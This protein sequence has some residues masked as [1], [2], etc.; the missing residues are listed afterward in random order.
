MASVR[1]AGPPP[2]PKTLVQ[3]AGLILGQ[4]NGYFLSG[5][6][7]SDRATSSPPTPRY[8]GPNVLGVA[9]D[10][11]SGNAVSKSRPHSCEVSLTGRAYGISNYRRAADSAT[12]RFSVALNFL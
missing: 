6:H 10:C 8:S 11:G 7:I 12:R 3:D 2:I 4:Y 1:L 5:T 9:A